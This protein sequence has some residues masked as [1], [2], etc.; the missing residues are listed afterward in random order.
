MTGSRKIS[1]VVATKSGVCL[2]FACG[3]RG[4]SLYPVRFNGRY[5][6]MSKSG[7]LA[8]N[9][10]FTDEGRFSEG[11]AP[12]RMAGRWG[13]IDTKGRIAINPQFDTADH[14]TDGAALIG[15]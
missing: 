10:Q 5:G 11:L 13:Y 3:Y 1:M 14:F 12:V 6:Y 8:I 7:K 15:I 4:S 2:L 9:P